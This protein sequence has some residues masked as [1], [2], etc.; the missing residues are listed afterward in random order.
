M[1]TKS[2]DRNKL[3]LVIGPIAMLACI[4]LLP[5]NIFTT[6]EMRAAVGTVVWM[7]IWWVSSCV[8]YAVTAFLPIAINSIIVMSPMSSVIANYSSETI[9]LR[10]ICDTLVRLIITLSGGVITKFSSARLP[11]QLSIF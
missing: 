1:N 3:F 8:D 10:F 4:L 7:A 6:F 2:F 11:S 9:L 5:Q